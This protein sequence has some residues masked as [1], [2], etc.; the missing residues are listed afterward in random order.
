MIPVT[1]T[2]LIFGVA[3]APLRLDARHKNTTG[4]ETSITK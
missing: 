4:K 1:N 2:Y 3:E